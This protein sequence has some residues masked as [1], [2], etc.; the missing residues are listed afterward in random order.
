MF[1]GQLCGFPPSDLG[2]R[3]GRERKMQPQSENSA[4]N[5]RL[6]RSDLVL[7]WESTTKTGTVVKIQIEKCSSS[8][9]VLLICYSG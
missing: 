6:Q 4:A 2:K 3:K 9:Y 1:W 7:R 8:D 5:K